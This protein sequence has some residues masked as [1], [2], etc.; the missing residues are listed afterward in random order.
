MEGEETTRSK[1]PMQATMAEIKGMDG[2]DV[3]CRE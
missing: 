1:N 2:R 3:G